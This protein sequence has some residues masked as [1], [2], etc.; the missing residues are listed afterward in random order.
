MMNKIKFIEWDSQL[1][2]GVP[3]LDKQHKKLMKILNDTIKH[4]NGNK[5]DEMKYF[6]KTRHKAEKYLKKHFDTEEKMLSKTKYDKLEEH[7]TEHNEFYE[8]IKK[9][10]EEI[11]NNIRDVNLFKSTAYIKEW[12]LN[13]I[14]NYDKKANKYLMEL[15]QKH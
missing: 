14:K 13:H 15:A 12:L 3:E 8:E 2:I 7:R 1:S 6:K 9:T 10:N 5:I 11:E 4:S